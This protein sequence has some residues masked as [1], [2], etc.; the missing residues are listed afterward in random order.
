MDKKKAIEALS[1]VYSIVSFVLNP[2]NLALLG[3]GILMAVV[4]IRE[5][6]LLMAVIGVFLLGV[7][8]WKFIEILKPK[9]KP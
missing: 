4:G 5:R 8:G 9:T 3:A 2:L 6:G 7:V 1:L